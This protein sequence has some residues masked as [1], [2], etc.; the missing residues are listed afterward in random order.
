MKIRQSMTWELTIV[1]PIS[2]RDD[3]GGVPTAES[4]NGQKEWFQPQMRIFN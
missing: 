2:L 3:L 1:N 4:I